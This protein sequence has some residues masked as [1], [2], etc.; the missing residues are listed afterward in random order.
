MILPS[1]FLMNIHIQGG[2]EG[3]VKLC[4]KKFRVIRLGLDLMGQA[5]KDGDSMR[6]SGHATVYWSV[7]LWL[8]E[9]EGSVGWGM[10][11]RL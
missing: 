3:G 11:Y 5:Q 2:A 8:V 10:D 7:D 6:L 1:D 9:A 4:G